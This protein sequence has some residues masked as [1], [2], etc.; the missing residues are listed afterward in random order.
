MSRIKWDQSGDRLYQ[1]GDKNGVMYPQNTD[2]TYA[3]GAGWNGLTAV[4]ESPSGAEPTDLYADDMKYLSIRSKEEFGFTIQCYDYPDEFDQCNGYAEIAAGVKIGQQAR[5]AFG[6]SYTS[7]LGNDTMGDDYGYIIHL[8]YNA[9]ASPSERSHSTVNDS[10]DAIEFSYECT[11]IPVAVEGFR[12][13]STIEIDSTAFKTTEEIARLNAF[14]DV[15]WGSDGGT[16]YTAAEITDSKFEPGLVYFERSGTEGSYVYT[17]TEAT[18]PVA[19][20]T[21]Y[22]NGARTPYL[23]LPDEVARLLSAS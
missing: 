16:T 17:E 18:T 22:T 11:T 14:L 15:I 23:P 7:I 10:P 19:G 2:G 6:F 3:K 1:T 20:T 4:T 13:T 12:P 9:T 21:Y 5:H 8:F